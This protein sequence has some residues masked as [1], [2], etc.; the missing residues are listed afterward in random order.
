MR[1]GSATGVSSRKASQGV[2]RTFPSVLR[3][4]DRL[5]NEREWFSDICILL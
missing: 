4:L 1:P 2:V 5:L 3:S